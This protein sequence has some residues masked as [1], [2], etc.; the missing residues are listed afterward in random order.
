[1]GFTV[2]YPHWE[3]LNYFKLSYLL[4]PPYYAWQS[5]LLGVVC[6]V[7]DLQNTWSIFR[8]CTFSPAYEYFDDGGDC[9]WL[10]ILLG[11]CRTWMAFHPCEFVNVLPVARHG[12]MTIIIKGYSLFNRKEVTRYKSVRKCN[13]DTVIRNENQTSK[14]SFKICKNVTC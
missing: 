2:I 8:K 14:N 1:M 11:K 13:S 6:V 7:S 9:V 4:F 10:W 12:Q 5:V 3:N